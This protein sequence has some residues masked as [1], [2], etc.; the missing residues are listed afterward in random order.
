MADDHFALVDPELIE[1]VKAL[2]DF[3]VTAQS[4][5]LVRKRPPF[6]TAPAPALQPQFRT[7][8]GS[9]GAPD[10]R[11]MVIDGTDGKS[12]SPAYLHMHGGGFVGGRVDQ[13]PAAYQ[14]LAAAC[15]CLIVSVDYR[16]APEVRFPGA[17]EDNYAALRWLHGHAAELG[18]DPSRIAIGGESAGGG[19]AAMLAIAAR[20]RGEFP[21]S[22]QMLIYPMLD[23]RTGSTL[24][25]PPHVGRFIW[26]TASN[27]FGWGALLGQSP[28]LNK[29][30][31]GSV[32]ARLE[33]LAGL[34]PTFIS[35]GG[36]DLFAGEDI[37]YAS[38]LNAAGVPVELLV[39]PGAYHAF[40]ALAPTARVSKQFRA[41]C[42]AALKRGLG[43]A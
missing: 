21:I 9:R 16:L 18:I 30:P 41:A 36:L 6:P 31:N 40:D 39:V 4:L 3:T 13:Y 11:V 37:T 23:D 2:P 33:D 19:H 32:P 27:R 1:A 12:A 42:I 17:L 29:V 22:F 34:P 20:D 5:P 8:P 26:N 14:A 24:S 28:G 43:L 7:I 35:V 15:G 38:R 25:V 10:V